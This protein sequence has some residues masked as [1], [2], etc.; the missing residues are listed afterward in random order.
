MLKLPCHCYVSVQCMSIYLVIR[1]KALL[2]KTKPK[3]RVHVA[4]HGTGISIHQ[5]SCHFLSFFSCG[6]ENQVGDWP[7]RAGPAGGI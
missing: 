5:Q 6:P 7:K 3:A 1:K 2:H 4:W